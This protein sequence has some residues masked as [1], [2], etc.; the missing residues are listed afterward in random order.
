MSRFSRS[1]KDSRV[2]VTGAAS[3]MGLATARAFAEE[4]AHVALTDHLLEPV[5]EAGFLGRAW[6]AMRLWIQ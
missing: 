1:L 6:D 3:G 4:G 2:L 5:E